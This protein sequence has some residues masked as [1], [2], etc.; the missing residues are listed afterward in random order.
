MISFL[1]VFICPYLIIMSFLDRFISEI[2]YFSLPSIAI[3]YLFG[4]R[5]LKKISISSV[6]GIDLYC[7][8]Q[9]NRKKKLFFSVQ[10][11]IF[12][13][14]GQR[15]YNN[16]LDWFQSKSF[17]LITILIFYISN[18]IITFNALSTSAAFSIALD[19]SSN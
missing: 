12:Y 16:I 18:L 4:Q 19:K 15:K 8:G 11:I 9:I 7:F 6:H 5:N 2:S 14:F 17:L 10:I 1:Q 3:S 13:W